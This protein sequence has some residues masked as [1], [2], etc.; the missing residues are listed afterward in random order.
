MIS[1]PPYFH[2][3]PEIC[4]DS[5]LGSPSP[6]PI[7]IVLEVLAQAGD[8]TMGVPKREAGQ[9]GHR[10]G[11]APGLCGVRSSMLWGKDTFPLGYKLL[12]QED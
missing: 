2:G 8:R 1:Q 10:H 9:S 5:E 4:D 6:V 3:L 12:R 7:D 11:L